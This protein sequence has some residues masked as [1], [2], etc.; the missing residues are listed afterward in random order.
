MSKFKNG[1]KVIANIN[2]GFNVGIIHDVIP[3]EVRCYTKQQGFPPQGEPQ[4]EPIER[5]N[6][7]VCIHADGRTTL[8]GEGDLIKLENAEE[9][10]IQRKAR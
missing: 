1:D 2:N 4:G 9:F 7:L 5:Y 8:V 6:Y 3:Y 10:W